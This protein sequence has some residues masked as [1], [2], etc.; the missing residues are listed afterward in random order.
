MLIQHGQAENNFPE[1]LRVRDPKSI[2]FGLK[3][4]ALPNRGFVVRAS[5]AIP[6]M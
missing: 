3:P 6:Q 2:E 1:G 4:D 5:I